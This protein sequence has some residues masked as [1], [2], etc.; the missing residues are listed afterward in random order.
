MIIVWAIRGDKTESPSKNQPAPE[1]EYVKR[2]NKDE[3]EKIFRRR[4]TDRRIEQEY[5]TEEGAPSTSAEEGI[6]DRN[7]IDDQIELPFTANE[8][9]ADGSRFKLYKRTLINSEIYAK[10][11]DFETAI[12]LYTG[13]KDRILDNDIKNKIESNIFYLNSFKK[14]KEADF[15]KKIESIYRGQQ[16][17]ITQK[18]EIAPAP[19]PTINITLP[20]KSLINTE[21]IMGQIS[22]RINNELTNLTELSTMKDEF[23][24][25]KNRIE[26]L[27][28][29]R[30]KTT[31]ELNRLKGMQEDKLT[32]ENK[33][34]LKE[35]KDRIDNLSDV[36][37]AMDELHGKINEIKSLGIPESEKQPAI[38]PAK[39]DSPVPVHFD[40]QPVLDILDKIDRQRRYE[41]LD[42][43]TEHKQIEDLD[44]SYKDLLNKVS[45]LEEKIG[46]TGA[47]IKDKPAAEETEYK[48]DE[49]VKSEKEVERHFDAEEDPNEFDLLSEIGKIK[50]D[51]TITDEEIFEKILR[52]D[53]KGKDT[54]D[55]EIVGEAESNEPDFTS[56]D[57]ISASKLKSDQDFYKKFIS[58]D[59]VKKRELPILKV[60][61]DFKK[62]PDEFSLSRE[63]NILEYAF[64]K[65]KPMLQRADEFIK[66]RHVKDAINYYKV[67]LDQNI[68]IEFKAML[69]RNIKDLSEYLEKYF[70]SE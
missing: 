21:E 54:K 18:I 27:S 22:N 9:I 10:K 69:R 34:F 43:K 25:L 32:P 19:P 6:S 61:Y 20:E 14:K 46:S 57:P 41:K 29:E 24:S 12:S 66:N 42:E 23:N 35:I 52:D 68:P 70:A 56:I 36:K 60:S 37:I 55:F 15:K 33:E 59:R 44:S 49:T 31:D 65:Y 48:H 53:K 47:P 3:P 26:E 51:S 11:G 40:P 58:T 17:E 16:P 64:Y 2:E 28:A 8:I 62:L 1:R 63:K 67:V 4:A 5:P 45:N 13:V 30:D 50:D 7:P 39:Y 38:I